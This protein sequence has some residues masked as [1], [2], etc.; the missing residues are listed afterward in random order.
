MSDKFRWIGKDALGISVA[1]MC[2]F[3]IPIGTARFGII[4]VVFAFC[5]ALVAGAISV[6]RPA[7]IATLCWLIQTL[8]IIHLL[9]LIVSHGHFDAN[10]L[11]ALLKRGVVL[12]ISLQHAPLWL[13]GVYLGRRIRFPSFGRGKGSPGA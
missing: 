7:I 3:L 8:I 13:A 10:Q 9:V 11:D 5:C 2:Y 6:G 4:N 12:K 1:L